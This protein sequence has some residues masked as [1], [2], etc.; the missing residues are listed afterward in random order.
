MGRED[1]LCHEA[2]TQVSVDILPLDHH[3]LKIYRN[4]IASAYQVSGNSVQLFLKFKIL[5]I[6]EPAL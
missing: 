6:Y 4:L 5:L 3:F 1:F 2:S